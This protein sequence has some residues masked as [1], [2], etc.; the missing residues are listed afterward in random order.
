MRKPAK[1]A[2]AV[3]GATLLPAAVSASAAGT[4]PTASNV[5]VIHA[6]VSKGL[7]GVG[8]GAIR[9]VSDTSLCHDYEAPLSWS[10]QGPKGDPGVPGPTGATGPQGERGA[11]GAVGPQGPKGD[12]GATGPAGPAGP[13]GPQGPKGDKGDT[14][15]AGPAGPPGPQGPAGPGAAIAA[16]ITSPIIEIPA[17]DGVAG[18]VDCPDGMHPISGGYEYISDLGNPAPVVTTD[19]ARPKLAPTGWFVH[20]TNQSGTPVA[21]KIEVNCVQ[22]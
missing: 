6:C 8:Q 10:Q 14:G 9:I 4:D 15:A 13:V 7:L 21:A 2:G 16:V 5:T 17:N 19:G 22:G 1:I 3:L 12:T 20:F 11:T 18:S